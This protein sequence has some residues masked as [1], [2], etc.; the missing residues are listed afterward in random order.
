MV[1]DVV[2]H[3]VDLV[4]GADRGAGL[5]R[6]HEVARGIGEHLAHLRDL[7][8]RGRVEVPNPRVVERVQHARMGVALDGVED[9]ARKQREEAPRRGG[10]RLGPQAVDG[11][12][13]PQR[14]DHRFG[15]RVARCAHRDDPL[16]RARS[17]RR[18]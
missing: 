10:E 18:A 8:E 7:G 16:S 12:A 9:P 14:G 11:V 2:A 4:G 13:R 15:V 17:A 5:D 1:D 3:A 6:V